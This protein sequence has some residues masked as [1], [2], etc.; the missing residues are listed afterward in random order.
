MN[1]KI[2]DI[3]KNNVNEISEY[4][5]LNGID[6]KVFKVFLKKAMERYYYAESF[7]EQY[8]VLIP[9]INFESIFNEKTRNVEIAVLDIFEEM[10]CMKINIL[11]KYDITNCSIQLE[12]DFIKVHKL[13]KTNGD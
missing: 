6:R 1:R 7:Y 13:L 2:K 10:A 9:K 4:Y 5:D 3:V 8:T 11:N 12:F